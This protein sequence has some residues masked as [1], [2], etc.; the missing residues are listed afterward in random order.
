MTANSAFVYVTK[1]KV[2]FAPFW[3]TKHHAMKKYEGME[4][5]LHALTSA[6]G[7]DEWSASRPDRFTT[8]ERAP[9][10]HWRGGLVGP[11]ALSQNLKIK[12]FYWCET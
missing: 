1:Q 12:I 6:L 5:Q 10:T 3:L 2:K 4:V 11:R 8:G 9:C 7:G